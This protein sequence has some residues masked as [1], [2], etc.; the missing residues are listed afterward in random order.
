MRNVRQYWQEVR[1]IE[2]GLPEFVW[3]YSQG[4]VSQVTASAAARL[5]HAETHRL[6][7][8]A[9]VQGHRSAEE[10]AYRRARQERMKREGRALVLPTG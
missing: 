3:L 7:T 8:D 9:E 2:A 5:L 6:A 4:V 10:E 1:A